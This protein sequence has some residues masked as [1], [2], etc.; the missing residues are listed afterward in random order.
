[1]AGVARPDDPALLDRVVFR[2]ASSSPRVFVVA[3]AYDGAQMKRALQDF[4]AVAAGGKTL[5]LSLPGG[6]LQAGGWADLVC[7]VGHNGLMDAPVGQTPRRVGSGGP[8]GAIVLACKSTGYFSG[9]LK[10]ASCPLL[11]GTT[12]LMAPEAYTLDAALRSWA[13]SGSPVDV[14]RAAAGAYAKYQ[15]CSIRAARRLF[16]A[17]E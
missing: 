1:V 2:S 11:V 14:R 12:G 7:F 15:K 3:D 5:E 9:P 13:A 16:A 17:A 8:E 4:F 6:A 10:R